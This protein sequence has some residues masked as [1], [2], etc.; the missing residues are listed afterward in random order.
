MLMLGSS[1]FL[2]NVHFENDLTGKSGKKLPWTLNRFV[3][4]LGALEALAVEEEA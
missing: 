2:R 3:D 4:K 1:E